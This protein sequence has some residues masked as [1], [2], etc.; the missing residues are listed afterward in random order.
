M[1]LILLWLGIIAHLLVMI[2]IY[3]GI[4]RIVEI[5]QEVVDEENYEDT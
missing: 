2:G 3:R 5:M 1:E 4:D